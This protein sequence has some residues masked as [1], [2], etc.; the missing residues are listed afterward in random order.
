MSPF[1][2]VYHRST[3]KVTVEQFPDAVSAMKARLLCES[4]VDEDVEI[5]V[6]GSESD[7]ELRETHSRYFKDPT[8]ILE[9]SRKFMDGNKA[10]A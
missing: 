5:V 1:L 6:L 4:K 3:G 7:E 9:S 8:E 2:V 10:S